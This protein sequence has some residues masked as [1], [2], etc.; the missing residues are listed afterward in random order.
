MGDPI[1]KGKG[2]AA[3]TVRSPSVHEL[4]MVL[5]VLTC[6]LSVSGMGVD[7]L[8]SWIRDPRAPAWLLSIGFF[9]LGVGFSILSLLLPLLS[10]PGNST[11]ARQRWRWIDVAITRA[12]LTAVGVNLLLAAYVGG[13]AYIARCPD[14][15]VFT[16]SV[17]ANLA[18]MGLAVMT[19]PGA[20]PRHL[21]ALQEAT[22]LRWHG[23]ALEADVRCPFCSTEVAPESAAC[24]RSCE[25]LHHQDCWNEFGGCSVFACGDHAAQAL[26]GKP[27]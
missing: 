9:F 19:T 23:A 1:A 13:L 12:S 24:C 26:D 5:G 17:V 25:T 27:V 20:R 10:A 7:V 11:A 15:V 22:L 8:A 3:P 16:I 4:A 18:A 2:V 21:A 6:G 14:W